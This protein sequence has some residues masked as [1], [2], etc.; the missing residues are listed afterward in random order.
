MK[1]F[2]SKKRQ[3]NVF[4]YLAALSL[5][6]LIFILK[7]YLPM[8]CARSESNNL[9]LAIKTR[10][11]TVRYYMDLRQFISWEIDDKHPSYSY[12]Y[13]HIGYNGFYAC[14]RVHVGRSMSLIR[15][16]ETDRGDGDYSENWAMLYLWGQWFKLGASK[17]G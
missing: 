3:N 4:L 2:D 11:R 16:P 14:V 1:H 13:D 15:T 7:I 6:V 9:I 12:S 8:S 5:L 17:Q 10:P